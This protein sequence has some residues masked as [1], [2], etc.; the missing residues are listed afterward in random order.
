MPELRIK[1]FRMPELHLPEMS[2][3]DISRA[4]GDATR[5]VDLSRFDPRR[6][7]LPEVAGDIS[8]S[9][10]RSTCPRPSPM[11]RARPARAGRSWPSAR[12]SLA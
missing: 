10:R 1:E 9:C 5:D 2:R 3:D 11:R 8:A 12:S 4:I 6:V 7:D